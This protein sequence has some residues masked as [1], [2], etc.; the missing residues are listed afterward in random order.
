[1]GLNASS[2]RLRVWHGTSAQLGLL[3]MNQWIKEDYK[4]ARTKGK[5]ETG[6]RLHSLQGT[7]QH[8]LTGT[9]AVLVVMLDRAEHEPGLC[10]LTGSVVA[11]SGVS[12]SR[13]LWEA[14]CVRGEKGRESASKG[15]NGP[16]IKE[17]QS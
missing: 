10:P 2:S 15:I 14:G 6:C 1:M 9:G 5:T 3:K 12:G 13:G 4:A 8:F 17:S 7:H 16:M 11:S